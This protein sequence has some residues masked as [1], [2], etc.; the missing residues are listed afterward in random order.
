MKSKLNFIQEMRRLT[1]QRIMEIRKDLTDSDYSLGKVNEKRVRALEDILKI[2][3][4]LNNRAEAIINLI[5]SD[6][7][8]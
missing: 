6:K 1:E 3:M 2:N 7:I 8:H 4:Y 5:K